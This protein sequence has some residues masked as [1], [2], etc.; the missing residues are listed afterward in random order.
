MEAELLNA[1]NNL[2]KTIENDKNVGRWLRA[3]DASKYLTVSYPVFLTLVRNGV[4][5]PHKLDQYDVAVT[6]FDRE[7][8]DEVISNL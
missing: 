2:S 5:K 8:L 1:V 3:K 6:L 4:I 7:E